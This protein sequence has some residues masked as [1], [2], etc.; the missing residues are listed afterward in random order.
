[1]PYGYFGFAVL[2]VCADIFPQVLGHIDHMFQLLNDGSAEVERKVFSVVVASGVPAF[3]PVIFGGLNGDGVEVVES[4]R[5]RGD[6][7]A[8]LEGVFGVGR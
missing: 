4:A 6:D 8:R 3:V 5:E 7:G 2:V 1:L